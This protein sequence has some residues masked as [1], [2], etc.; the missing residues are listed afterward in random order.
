MKKKGWFFV[1]NVDFIEYVNLNVYFSLEEEEKK[2]VERLQFIYKY[3]Y[4]LE[5]KYRKII[6][7]Y[8]LQEKLY[9][10]IVF[11]MDFFISGV[12]CVVKFRVIDKL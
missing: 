7:V 5:L 4:F 3:F 1:M 10:E 9:E 2:K 8:Y 12:V 6:V 11:E